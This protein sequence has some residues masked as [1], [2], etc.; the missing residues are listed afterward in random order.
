MTKRVGVIAVDSTVQNAG[1]VTWWRLCGDVDVQRLFRAWDAR[2]WSV[3]DLPTQPSNTSTLRRVLRDQFGGPRC[4]IQSL[5]GS[6][7]AVVDVAV[8]STDTSARQIADAEYTTRFK[9]RLDEI[10]ELLESDGLAS[11]EL[12]H[13]QTEYD[14]ARNTYEASTLSGWLVGQVEQRKAIRLRDT[15]G[16]YFVPEG[17]VDSWRAFGEVIA[18]ASASRV[19]EVPA[20]KNEQAV[21]A[22]VEALSQELHAR[23]AGLD[24]DID[25]RGVRGLRSKAVRCEELAGKVR[26]YE[27]L[28]STKL[29]ALTDLISRLNG[30]IVQAVLVAE[31]EAADGN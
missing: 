8:V 2:G 4:L 30:R 16:I 5:N 13:L 23:V 18:E 21:V 11:S 17:Y 1:A 19:Y 6:A 25:E 26:V 10:D 24:Q 15:G 3:D 7:Y 31:A 22:L 28:F 14:R 27:A 20:V 29:D 9:I 12:A